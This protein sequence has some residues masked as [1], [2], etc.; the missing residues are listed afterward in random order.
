MF[1]SSC[2]LRAAVSLSKPIPFPPLAPAPG[3]RLLLVCLSRA[4]RSCSHSVSQ[5]RRRRRTGDELSI[6]NTAGSTSHGTAGQ[7]CGPTVKLH[8]M[9]LLYSPAVWPRCATLLYS[10]A[11]IEG[12]ALGLCLPPLGAGDHSDSAGDAPVM[13]HRQSC[14][15]QSQ[16]M[17]D[18]Q[19]MDALRPVQAL[20]HPKLYSGL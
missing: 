7:S 2:L 1:F 14:A 9:A 16:H 3:P 5:E 10:P 17:K 12:S 13:S 6:L 15:F 8:Y 11:S 18:K 4:L 19:S 20:T